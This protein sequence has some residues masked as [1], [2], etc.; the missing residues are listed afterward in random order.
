MKKFK[1]YTLGCKVNHSETEVM[2]KLFE[3]KGYKKAK[4]KE[5]SD[6]Y[7]I[8]TCTV[9]NLSDRKSRQLIQ[10]AKKEN[11]DSIVAVVGCYAQV[12]PKEVEKIENVDIIIGT[13]KKEKIVELYDEILLKKEKIL[14]VDSIKDIKK[15]N[16]ID[17]DDEILN[18]R[19]FLKIQDGCNM[20]CSYC[21]IPYARG[22]TRS[23]E[24][25]NI[26]N[27]V[28]SLGEKG[29]KEIVLT[30]IHVASY[31]KDLEEKTSLIELLEKL[32]EIDSIDRIRLSSIEPNVINKHFLDRYSKLEKMCDHFHLSLQS[33]DNR[34][35]KEMNRK[36]DT[37]QFLS[38]VELAKSYYPQI[39]LT[40]DII[41]GFP[42]ETDEEFE[43]SCEF[44]RKVKFSKIHVFKYSQR[45]GT[46]A[47]EMKNQ[48]D[49]K[50]KNIRSRDL[51]ELGEEVQKSVLKSLIG[52]KTTV[53]IEEKSN[54]DEY[55]VEG[56]STNYSRVIVKGDIKKLKG[57]IVEVIIR[58]LY[59]D[60]LLGEIIK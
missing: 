49:G 45:K 37:E 26:L 30:G 23:R 4:D 22:N 10:K 21:I 46:P 38:S 33:G 52:V 17:I 15:F 40:T 53:L 60:K 19:A 2:T 1:I 47:A 27:K 31:G 18:T 24:V 54:Y 51:I 56:Y 36:Y 44:V 20:Y 57:K 14:A 48:I 50:V 12:S 42:G 35:L 32:N 55:S 8:N 7:V 3:E 43:N 28:R 9:T 59:K 29:I 11:Q 41:V 34:I 5:V 16:T 58:E 6:I 25:E 39:G 13:D